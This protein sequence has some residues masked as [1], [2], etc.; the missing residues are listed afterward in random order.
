MSF[1]N[2]RNVNHSGELE[3]A[4]HDVEE[5]KRGMQLKPEVIF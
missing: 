1:D 4:K 5:V 3:T 2:M